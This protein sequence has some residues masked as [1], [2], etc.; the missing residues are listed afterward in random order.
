MLYKKIIKVILI[1]II[2][3]EAILHQ[4]LKKIIVMITNQKNKRHPGQV[5]KRQS[6]FNLLID[7]DIDIT[8][9]IVDRHILLSNLHYVFFDIF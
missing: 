2:I 5:K 3:K 8:T 4:V 6:Y 9:N 1:Q 7:C